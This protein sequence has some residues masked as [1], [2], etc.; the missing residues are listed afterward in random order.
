[1]RWLVWV[2]AVCGVL[3]AVVQMCSEAEP[4]GPGYH[5]R[6]EHCVWIWEGFLPCTGEGEPCTR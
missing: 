1:M 6:N 3:T 4:C 5:P 2:M